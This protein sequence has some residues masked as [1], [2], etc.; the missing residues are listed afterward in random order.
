MQAGQSLYQIDPATYQ[1]NY[2]SA[3]GELAKSEA[4]A[5]IAHLTVK[6]YV[7][8]VGT[9]TSASR[10]TTRPLLMLARPMPPRLPQKPQSKALASILLI[11]KLVAPISGRIGKSTV[12]EGA[13]V[14][15]GQTTELATVQQLDPDPR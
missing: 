8:L 6:R 7:P 1:A 11:P 15:N 10:S 9:N 3:K 12:T 2:D 4:A 14:T 13:L 5:A